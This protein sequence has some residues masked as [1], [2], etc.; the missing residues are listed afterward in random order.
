[1]FRALPGFYGVAA[2]DILS[3]LNEICALPV[4]EGR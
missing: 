3:G 2:W 4:Q 1:M